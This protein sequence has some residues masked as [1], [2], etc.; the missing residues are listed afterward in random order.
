LGQKSP[1]LTLRVLLQWELRPAYG[2]L[3]LSEHELWFI[4]VYMP[5]FCYFT[6]IKSKVIIFCSVLHL[7][8]SVLRCGPQQA[9][10]HPPALI[11]IPAPISLW[12]RS[13]RSPFMSAARDKETTTAFPWET[14]QGRREP[15]APLRCIIGASHHHGGQWRCSQHEANGRR[16]RA[17]G[18]AACLGLSKY[19]LNNQP[20]FIQCTIIPLQSSSEMHG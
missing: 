10:Q 1:L 3:L 12:G 2:Y 4:Y 18:A 17:T 13:P 16:L 7:L 14:G 19:V 5:N 11:S 20:V 6:L 9:A 8:P 15:P